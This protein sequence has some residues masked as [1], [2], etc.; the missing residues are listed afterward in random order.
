MRKM[1][2]NHLL[3]IA[4]P[5]LQCSS[6]P[7]GWDRRNALRVTNESG[8]ATKK[9]DLKS[10]ENHSGLGFGHASN[11]ST[12]HRVLTCQCCQETEVDRNGTRVAEED[13]FASCHRHGRSLLRP[14]HRLRPSHRPFRLRA[15]SASFPFPGHFQVHWSCH[16]LRFR[17][18]CAYPSIDIR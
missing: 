2:Q 17:R 12:A 6:G 10:S 3:T 18:R 14:E 13:Y 9:R 16:L 1:P 11:A 15:C 7:R 5:P 4:P 8:P